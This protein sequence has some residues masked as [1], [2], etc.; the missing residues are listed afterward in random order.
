MQTAPVVFYGKYAI[1]PD[2]LGRCASHDGELARFHYPLHIGIQQ[3]EVLAVERESNLFGFSRFQTDAFKAGKI[4][5]VGG[6]LL[7]ISRV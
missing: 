3:F 5:F 2:V 6:K 1:Q 7:N 4:L